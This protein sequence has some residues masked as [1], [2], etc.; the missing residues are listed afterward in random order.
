MLLIFL[1]LGG[2]GLSIVV[3]FADAMCFQMLGEDSHLYGNQR[4]WGAAG[5]GTLSFLAGYLVDVYS[6]DEYE[7]DYTIPFCLFL[8]FMLIDVLVCTKLKVNFELVSF[9]F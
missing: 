1:L 6:E 8:G 5:W 3:S 9:F 2:T 7:K 4:L